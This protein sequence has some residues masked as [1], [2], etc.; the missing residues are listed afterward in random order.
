M[1]PSESEDPDNPF[2]WTDAETTALRTFLTNA[3]DGNRTVD[4]AVVDDAVAGIALENRTTLLST[5]LWRP[6]EIS[7]SRAQAPGVVEGDAYDARVRNLSPDTGRG[8]WSSATLLITGDL[9]PPSAPTGLVATSAPG[10]GY[11]TW[12]PSPEPDVAF[13]EILT[14]TNNATGFTV[15]D[16]TPSTQW[17]FQGP[18]FVAGT[19]RF[20]RVRAVDRRGNR[21]ALSTYADFVPQAYAVGTGITIHT[22]SGAPAPALGS[23]GDYYVDTVSGNSYFKLATGWQLVQD[24]AVREGAAVYVVDIADGANPVA[25]TTTLSRGG[26]IPPAASVPV[27]SIVI[28]TSDGRLWDWDGSDFVFRGSLSGSAVL[29]GKGDPAATLGKNGDFYVDTDTGNAWIK[30]TGAWVK[31]IDLTAIDG[32]QT[33]MVDIADDATPAPGTATTAG[34]MIPVAANIHE[35]SVAVDASDGRIWEWV[36][37]TMLFV[38]RG[39][40]S[41]Q[42]WDVCLTRPATAEHGDKCVGGDGRIWVYDRTAGWEFTGITIPSDDSPG[43]TFAG[44]CVYHRSA[45]SN[46]PPPDSFGNPG[47]GAYNLNGLYWVKGAATG[48]ATTGTWPQNPTGSFGGVPG[49]RYWIT[50]DETLPNYGTSSLPADVNVVSILS[51]GNIYRW[52]RATGNWVL[53]GNI[54]SPTGTRVV[55][56]PTTPPVWTTPVR[57]ANGT[58][59]A[60]ARWAIVANALSYNIRLQ[61]ATATVSSVTQ[62]NARITITDLPADT[63]T[64]I[65]VS[66][67]GRSADA[68]SAEVSSQVSTGASLT[69]RPGAPSGLSVT[70]NQATGDTTFVWT[71]TTDNLSIVTHSILEI[72]QGDNVY[73]EHRIDGNSATSLTV[74]ALPGGTYS[75]SLTHYTAAGAGPSVAIAAFTVNERVSATHPPYRN[76]RVTSPASSG[77]AD[78]G[79]NRNLRLYDWR[80]AYDDP[81]G[82][83]PTATVVYEVGRRAP[84]TSVERNDYGIFLNSGVGP[85]VPSVA[86]LKLTARIIAAYSGVWSDFI[87]D[88]GS[89]G[90]PPTLTI[91]APTAVSI[92]PS[93]TVQGNVGIVV[94]P[95]TLTHGTAPTGAA[96]NSIVVGFEIIVYNGDTIEHIENQV[97]WDKLLDDASTRMKHPYLASGQTLTTQY[98][99]NDLTPGLKR[100]EIRTCTLYGISSPFSRAVTMPTVGAP[101]DQI[102]APENVRVRNQTATGAT[103]RGRRPTNATAIEW[104][105]ALASTPQ[106]PINPISSQT[107]FPISVGPLTRNL[108]YVVRVRGRSGSSPNFTRGPYADVALNLG[109]ATPVAPPASPTSITISISTTVQ[110]RVTFTVPTV[111]GAT[112]YNLRV[113]LPA[114][115]STNVRHVQLSG[116]ARTWTVTGL[117][118]GSHVV[119]L[120][121]QNAGG[122]GP[123]EYTQAFVMPVIRQ[124]GSP[125]PDPPTPV[126]Q[127]VAVPFMSL[128]PERNLAGT[129]Q[130]RLNYGAVAAATIYNISSSPTLSGADTRITGRSLIMTP[131]G[132]GVTTT[133]TVRPED[134]S[135]NIGQPRS[136]ALTSNPPSVTLGTGTNI[137]SRFYITLLPTDIVITPSRLA[138]ISRY[139]VRVRLMG[140]TS[141]AGSFTITRAPQAAQIG[142]LTPGSVYTIYIRAQA[143][144]TSSGTLYP[145]T[146]ITVTMPTRAAWYS[147]RISG[148]PGTPT[149]TGSASGASGHAEGDHYM[150][151]LFGE[152]MPPNDLGND[153]DTAHDLDSDDRFEKRNGKWVVTVLGDRGEV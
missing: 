13:Y 94:T 36:P 113:Y 52:D 26:T 34:G 28:D 141:D 138:G 25:G 59:T 5:A 92:T 27:G 110:G 22:G 105:V 18:P 49:R 146:A 9:T 89:W 24:L 4:V 114:T 21:S 75:A 46:N 42:L 101:A 134:N 10:G 72:T 48:D 152:D 135:G 148:R 125:D 117:T 106:T 80:M 87:S 85:T 23:E 29:E 118:P 3:R 67:N 44:N 109:T 20:I 31:R 128:I 139:P 64:T 145:E 61:P 57:N 153:G 119:G 2:R 1:L 97:W 74:N 15:L 56:A 12:I 83:T 88:E 79:V 150:M 151:I 96:S 84:F 32:A 115:P 53:V 45:R 16:S 137:V 68:P 132:V 60:E 35:G 19:Q 140:A 112:L 65:Y 78:Q 91:P 98:A 136:V 90:T 38:Y 43:T 147:D 14:S 103:I 121:T 99:I 37:S 116:T 17:S 7:G 120:Q 41:G 40:V 8:P 122:F 126:D 133:I 30:A 63:V 129:Y 39:R 142:M 73:S 93:A 76:L 47:E 82:V 95:P 102:A 33:Y 131:P 81:A 54:C 111:T 62:N 130:W 144:S 71:N 66:V 11:L 127:L 69:L 123:Q 50:H 143:G 104:Y 149:P 70:V 55:Q 51:T 108:S 86:S 77:P 107:D 58:F 124:P 100:F 6:M